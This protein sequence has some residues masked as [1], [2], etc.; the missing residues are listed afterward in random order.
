MTPAGAAEVAVG[1]AAFEVAAPP[2]LI[3]SP[4]PLRAAIATNERLAITHFEIRQ[5]ALVLSANGEVGLD[6]QGRPAG[7]ISTQ[8]SDVNLLFER[9]KSVLHLDEPKIAPL[10]AILGLLQGGKPSITADLVARDGALFWGPIK[11]TDLQPLVR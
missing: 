2:T 8:A 7:K 4:D 1:D 3:A 11:L 6:P 9:I 5:G 10:R